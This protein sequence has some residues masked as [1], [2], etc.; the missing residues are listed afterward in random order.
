[1]TVDA[2]IPHFS[3]KMD[4]R[5]NEAPT[6]LDT[7]R[8]SEPRTFVC[9]VGQSSSAPTSSSSRRRRPRSSRRRR[10]QPTHTASWPGEQVGLRADMGRFTYQRDETEKKLQKMR[11]LAHGTPMQLTLPN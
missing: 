11:E 3:V 1:M 5:Q 8:P 2:E 9:A 7:D 10:S 4:F 6:D